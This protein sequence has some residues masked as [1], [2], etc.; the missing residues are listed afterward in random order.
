MEIEYHEA[1]RA[2]TL[3]K[4]GIDFARAGEVFGGRTLSHVDDRRDYGEERIQTVGRLG[5][6]VVMV[7]W[8]PR[9]AARRILSMRMCNAKEAKRYR[10]E[11]DRRG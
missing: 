7:V 9:G 10:S 6:K 11:L 8:T 3:E 1:K 2:L 4:R 5:G